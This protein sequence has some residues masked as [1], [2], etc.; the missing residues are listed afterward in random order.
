MNSLIYRL[1][2]IVA[3][4]GI[5]PFS[6]ICQG[7]VPQE[8]IMFYNVE[9]LFDTEDDSLK[10]DDEFLPEGVRYWSDKRFFN[11]LTHVSQVIMAASKGSLPSVIGLA[12]IENS[13][14][15]DLLLYKTPLGNL[16][17]KYVHKE[18]PDM[19]GI[20]VAFLYRKDCFTPISYQAIPVINPEDS[21]FKTR[22]ILYV[23]G[24]L[25]NDT[26][27]F[28]VNHWP[29]KYGGTLET[30][31]LRALA[32]NTL[33]TYTDSILT[34]NSQSKIII[35]G[36][37]NDSP[38][39]ESIKDVLEAKKAEQEIEEMNLYNLGFQTFEKGIGSNKYQEKWELIDQF[40]VSG[41][42]LTGKGLITNPNL[43]TV[44]KAPFLVEKDENHLGEKTNRTYIGFKYHGGFSDHLPILLDLQLQ[45]N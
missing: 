2:I 33:R 36:D 14:V 12:E 17:Y 35:M 26:I 8:K 19:R 45:S 5:M 31:S 4:L 27:H 41:S 28:F 32:A 23:K 24:I 20:D 42:L 34:L 25:S 40:I 3:F 11:K 30:K 22:D 7:D 13:K 39:D 16:G 38:V 1:I 37:F 15:L 21:T 18:S 6:G 29:S 9:N 43:F 10:N 44:F